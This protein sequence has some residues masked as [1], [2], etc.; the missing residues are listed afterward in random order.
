MRDSSGF[1]DT[2]VL[3]AYLF[4]E[5]GRFDRAREVLRRHVVK[6][7]SIISIHELHMYSVRFN[8][9]TDLQITKTANGTTFYSGDVI[10]YTL[11]YGV[12]SESLGASGIMIVDTYPSELEIVDSASGLVDT[13]NN[14]ITWNLP[15][16]LP[17]DNGFFTYTARVIVD[18]NTLATN[19]V[20][21]SSN[22]Y[23]HD[24]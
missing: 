10:D 8:V 9:G 1:Y 14:T 13:V 21:I 22:E 6:A 3:V 18:S 20:Q 7:L 23:D 16:M 24:L 4:R 5:E 19:T 11:N 12:V 15:D 2:N 17:G